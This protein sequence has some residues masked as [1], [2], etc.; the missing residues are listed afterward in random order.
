M[1]GTHLSVTAHAQD[2]PSMTFAENI[3]IHDIPTHERP[4]QKLLQ[5]GP[6]ALNSAELLSLFILTG[7]NG[8]SCL[9]ISRQ[10]ISRYGGLSPLGRIP[11]SA[12]AMETGIGPSKAAT[13]AAAYELGGRVAR[14]Q[15]NSAPLDTPEQIHKFYAPQVQHLAQE[16]VIVATV[17]CRLCHIGTNIVSVGSVN[18]T[19]AHP[20]EIMRPVI[21]RAA[22]GFVLVHNH[23]SGDPS[24]SRAD[25]SVTKRIVEVAETMQVRFIDHVIIG[26]VELGRAPYYSFRESGLIP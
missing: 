25:F 24:P 3:K 14:E 21:T 20:R 15:L 23:P 11:A 13:L 5:Y 1:I 9:D 16:Q 6:S 26:R 2:Q 19:S 8:W 17:D 12:L 22:F 4:R 7:H 18:E 10:L